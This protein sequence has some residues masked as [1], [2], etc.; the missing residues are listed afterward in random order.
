MRSCISTIQHM[1]WWGKGIF[2]SHPKTHALQPTGKSEHGKI[3]VGLTGAVHY[4]AIIV[5]YRTTDG[6]DQLLI[7][8]FKTV[9]IERSNQLHIT[10]HDQNYIIFYMT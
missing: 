5:T 7:Y 6:E 10:E 4:F 8:P 2:R 1:R 9:R 3:P